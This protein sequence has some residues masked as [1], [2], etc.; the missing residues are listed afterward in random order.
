MGG[1]KPFYTGWNRRVMSWSSDLLLSVPVQPCGDL[2][3]KIGGG[4]GDPRVGL[5]GIRCLRDLC[6][7][8]LM[9]LIMR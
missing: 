1:H 9:E 6:Y 3:G 5:T 4:D 7:V 2:A 8:A